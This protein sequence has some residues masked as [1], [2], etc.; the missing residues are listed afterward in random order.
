[1]KILS[2]LLLFF[3]SHSFCFAQQLQDQ[4]LWLPIIQ[5]IQ[6]QAPVNQTVQVI[7]TGVQLCPDQWG[8]QQCAVCFPGTQ[9]DYIRIGDPIPDGMD[10][11]NNAPFAISLWWKGGTPMGGDFEVLAGKWSGSGNNYKY[12]AFLYDN[13]KP[14]VAGE[15]AE[16]WHDADSIYMD[17]TQWHHLVLTYNKT[18]LVLFIDNKIVGRAVNAQVFTSDHPF[19]IGKGFKG[20]MDDVRVF[21]EA[22]WV[23]EVDSLFH[24]TPDCS[25]LSATT[26][27][28]EAKVFAFPNPVT[29]RLQFSVPVSFIRVIHAQGPLVY[30]QTRSIQESISTADWTP[31]WYILHVVDTVTS[32]PMV[33]R[34]LKL[35]H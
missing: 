6:N 4:V 10:F 29:E 28:P 35:D 18:D 20:A 2:F 1:M 33:Q 17:S 9:N 8:G 26:D 25:P 32:K 11:Q 14:L 19:I 22:L 13:N 12:G 30:Q 16:V 31:G 15:N 3:T 24:I 27:L 21:K 34:I 5:S 23:D 7:G